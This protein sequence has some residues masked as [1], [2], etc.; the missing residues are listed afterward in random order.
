MEI[1]MAKEGIYSQID[2]FNNY[3]VN[4]KETKNNK[5]YYINSDEALLKSQFI[6]EIQPD[7]VIK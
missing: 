7:R 4:S 3:I 1:M 5:Y 6:H 2:K